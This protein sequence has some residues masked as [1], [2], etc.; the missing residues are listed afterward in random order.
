VRL[1]HESLAIGTLVMIG[2]HGLALL[3]DPYLRPALGELVIPFASSYRPLGTAA[4]QLAG[5]GIAALA[6]T[7]YARTRIGAR[8][9]RAAHRLISVF[10]LL[11][12]VHGATAG[13]DRTAWWF[14]AAVFLPAAP[15][16]FTLLVR[17]DGV[18]TTPHAR[19]PVDPARAPR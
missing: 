15:A 6:L 13:T 5:Y 8:R 14:L 19:R 17:L 7:Y 18:V 1:L 12:L 11:A 4:G 2:C 10:W 16:L 3:L 9:W